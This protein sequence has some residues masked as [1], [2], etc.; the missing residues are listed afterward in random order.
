MHEAGHAPYASHDLNFDF[1]D[2]QRELREVILR[3]RDAS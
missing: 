1:T 3:F 2:K